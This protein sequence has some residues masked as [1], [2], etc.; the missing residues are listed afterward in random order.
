M[1]SAVQDLELCI[2]FS[3]ETRADQ[4]AMWMRK[5]N[6]ILLRLAIVAS[7]FLFFLYQYKLFFLLFAGFLLAVALQTCAA[8]IERHTRLNRKFSYT[9]TLL[10]LS[11]LIALLA[12]LIA[13][14]AI[15]ETGEIAALLPGSVHQA[16]NYLDQRAW[17]KYVV[18]IAQRAIHGS[19][20]GVTIANFALSAVHGVE[21][22]VVVLVVGFFGALS[23]VAYTRG[24]LQLL[25]ARFRA[26]GK[27]T[28]LDVIYTLRWWLLGQL[29]P[30]VF[31][32]AVTMIGLWLLHVPLA[33]TLG[34][35]TGLMIF[36]PYVGAILAAIPTILVGLTVSSKTA[37]WVLILYCIVHASEAYILTP[38]V[39]KRA[40]R[41]PPL[42]TIL[43]QL[44]MWSMAGL[45]GVLVA[46]PLAASA[47]V[48]VRVLYLKQ[49]LPRRLHS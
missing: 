45:I 40:V 46:T 2:S 26:K 31:L 11:G 18:R 24:L 48:L 12:L 13:P 30:M 42:L 41:L 5:I 22:L 43:A 20:P 32:G 3:M 25:P 33:F 21:A 16:K 1:P 28:G 44:F 4:N 9:V 23:P 34:L 14:R 39:Q 35:I 8:W 47:L 10:I 17:G 7:L 49:P 19:A 36:I 15:R 6:R 27:E 37:L 29:V 38:L